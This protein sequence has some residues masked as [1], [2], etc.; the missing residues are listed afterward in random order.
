MM[1]QYYTVLI[2][3]LSSFALAYAL[4][5]S[6]KH[7]NDYQLLTAISTA[8]V[9]LPMA[10]FGTSTAF[11]TVKTNPIFSFVAAAFACLNAALI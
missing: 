1:Q 6:V 9:H 10:A 4:F 11:L 7:W 3:A 8:F 2:K 5:Q